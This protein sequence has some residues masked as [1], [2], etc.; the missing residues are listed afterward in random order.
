[1]V[2]LLVLI[3]PSLASAFPHLTSSISRQALTPILNSI[4][5]IA[6]QTRPVFDQTQIYRYVGF[7]C[8]TLAGEKTVAGFAPDPSRQQILARF[9]GDSR[10]GQLQVRQQSWFED[11][12][13]NCNLQYEGNYSQQNA[14]IQFDKLLANERSGTE[15][16]PTRRLSDYWIQPG[17][18]ILLQLESPQMNILLRP[19]TYDRNGNDICGPNMKGYLLFEA[20][21]V[22]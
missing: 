1:M 21:P 2:F 8:P 22:S 17:E 6:S 9:S 4:G 13:G 16:S 18:L 11:D 3:L 10:Q 5:Q 20:L 15:C 12:G 14:H 7:W 19:L